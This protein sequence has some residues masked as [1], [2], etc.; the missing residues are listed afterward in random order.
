MKIISDLPA[1]VQSS[2]YHHWNRNQCW[3]EPVSLRVHPTTSR[4]TFH[5]CPKRTRGTVCQRDSRFVT[6]RFTC[7]RAWTM[8]VWNLSNRALVTGE[9]W[10]RDGWPLDSIREATLTV[11]PKRQYLNETNDSFSSIIEHWIYRGIFKPTTPATQGPTKIRRGRYG[12]D[13]HLFQNQS[14]TWMNSNTDLQLFLGPMS[15]TKMIDSIEK[16]QSHT[17]DFTCM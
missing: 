16:R 11:S 13:E 6:L 15:N 3:M 8:N 17:A 14:H 12:N 1:R 9:I 2:S 4:L 7:P 5:L 10:I